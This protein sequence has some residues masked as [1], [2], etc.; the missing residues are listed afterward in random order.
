MPRFHTYVSLAQ[1]M[2]QRSFVNPLKM[3][4]SKKHM[5]VICDLPHPI[6]QLLD[7]KLRHFA[8]LAFFAA[9]PPAAQFLR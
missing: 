1:A 2:N 9:N 6:A 5:N 7:F 3:P 4:W 8:Y